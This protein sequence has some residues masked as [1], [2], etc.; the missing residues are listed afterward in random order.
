MKPNFFLLVQCEDP[1]SGPS[2][3][4]ISDLAVYFDSENLDLQI[5]REIKFDYPEDD[6]IFEWPGDVPSDDEKRDAKDR[7][8]KKRRRGRKTAK[9]T[10][11]SKKTYCGTVIQKSSKTCV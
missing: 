4:V 8:K 11:K 2:F 9:K 3:C 7:E 10:K 1:K 6:S 5:N